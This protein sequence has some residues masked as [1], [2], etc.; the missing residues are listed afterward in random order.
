MNPGQFVDRMRVEA[1]QQIIDSSSRGLKEI[2]EDCGFQSPDA[3]RRT[4]VRVLGVTAAE[5]ASRFKRAI[6]HAPGS[7]RSVS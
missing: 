6:A 1:A 7:L 5:Y 4:F 3:M 2:A